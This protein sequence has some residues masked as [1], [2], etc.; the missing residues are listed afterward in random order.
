MQIV[1]QTRAAL[2]LGRLQIGD[3]LPTA[4]EVVEQVGV[5]PNTVFKAY[6]YLDDEGLVETRAG[7]GTFVVAVPSQAGSVQDSPVADRIGAWV[8]E[9]KAS[10]LGRRD[11]EVLVKAKL[12]TA[13][14]PESTG[15]DS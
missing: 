8:E 11:I 3:Q 2:L 14:P 12:D 5:N 15:D 13:F 6:R 7:S 1:E 10:G 9:A 4:R